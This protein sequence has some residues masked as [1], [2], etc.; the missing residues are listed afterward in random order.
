MKWK[1]MWTAVVFVLLAALAVGQAQEQYL[2]VYVAQ[3]KPE[4]RAEFDA[5]SKKI[6]AANR[7]NKGD[8]WLAMETVYGP[9][10]RVSFVSVRQGYGDAEKGTGAF[11]EAM[12]KTYGKPGT[13]KIFQ[14]FSQCLVSARSE[15]RRRRWDLS[16]NTPSDPAAMTKLVGEARW[17][18][19]TVVHV[20]PGQVAAFE[21]LLKDV[22]AARE[23]A[24]APQTVLVSQAVAGQEGTVFYVTTLQNS[25]AGFDAVP[26]IQQTLGDEGYA[27]FLKTSADVV[28]DSETMINR[29]LPELSNAPEEVA[30]I[31]PDFWRP[32][33]E[34]AAGAKA[35][36]KGGVVKA[37]GTTKEEK[38]KQP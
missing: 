29:F 7:Q 5:I 18:R 17:L 37:S 35:K 31:A 14:D 9:A 24:S 3:V 21:A 6:A 20:R 1:A 38:G 32:K 8:V 19:T 2:D 30:A 26:L 23:K 10:D 12:Q 28:A 15:F 13:E 34:V 33:T 25:L 27:K 16:S 4:K 36:T 22:K 11:F